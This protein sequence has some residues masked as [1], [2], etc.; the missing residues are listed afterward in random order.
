MA[1]F[2]LGHGLGLDSAESPY[3]GTDLGDAYDASPGPRRRAWCSCSSRSCGTRATAATGPRTCSSSPTTAGNLT[4][5]PYDPSGWRDRTEILPDDAGAAARPAAPGCSPRWRPHDLDV[6]VLGRVANIRY[7]SGVPRLWNAGTRAVRPGLRGRP[8]DRRDPPAEHVGRGRPRGDPPRPPLRHHVEPDELR[9]RCC[10]AIEGA[11]TARARRHRRHVAA[12]RPAARRW[13][14]RT[15]RSSTASRCL[16]RGP[17]GQDA[18]G[19]R[20][21]PGRRR[22]RRAGAGRGRGRAGARA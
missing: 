19:G 21:D 20:R 12:V 10:R 11:A 13:R 22:R 3:V 18:R 1:H 4:D 8:G 5:Y 17:P 7:V 15:P 9:R 6:L 16:R 2:Y 14:S